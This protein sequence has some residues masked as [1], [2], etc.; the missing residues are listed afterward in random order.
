MQ[1]SS[2]WPI[3]STLSGAATPGQSGAGSDGNEGVLSIPQSS[4]NTGTSLSDYLESYT[5]ISL[6]GVVT[7]Y[8]EAVGVFYS[9]IPLDKIRVGFILNFNGLLCTYIS[10]YIYI[11]IYIVIPRQ[12]SFV[13]SELISVARR[14]SF[15]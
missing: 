14:T 10:T 3:D 11:Y 5:G 2:I 8:R 1:F 13:Q 6:V 4:C 9:P 15:P 7:L 12:I